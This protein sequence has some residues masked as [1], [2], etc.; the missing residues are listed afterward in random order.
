MEQAR[1]GLEGKRRFSAAAPV[2]AGADPYA[3]PFGPPL[4]PAP[5]DPT[6]VRGAF[7]RF[8]SRGVSFTW[9]SRPLALA[10]AALV[11]LAATT[12]S[13]QEV[14]DREPNQ[15]G[16]VREEALEPAYA[17]QN[18]HPA[19]G[20]EVSLFA[21]EQDFPIGNPV[22]M[23]FDARGRL[24]VAT[25]PSYPQRLP[26]EAPDDKIVILE[27]R[28]GDGHAD[29]HTVFAS[30]LHLPTG[31][32]LGDGGAYVA[33]QPNLMFLEDTDGDD[34]ADRHEVI[35]HGFGTEDSHHSISAFTWGPGGALYFQEGTFHHSQVETPHGPVRLV[36]A[37]V[38]RY[39]PRRFHL[40]V[41]VSYPF[42][43]PWGHV[44]D[45]W[46][47]NF[48]AD[49]SGGDNYF[50]AP[51]TINAP[52]PR[53]RR[54]MNVF[55]SIVRPT[56]GCEIV[57]SRHFPDE[58]QG[59][60]LINNTIGFQGIKQHRVIEEGS[61][62]TSEEVEPLLYSTDIN[63]RPVDLQFGPD[64]SLYV[65]DWF[66]PLIGHMQ[67]SLRDE[68]RDH[69]HGRIWRVRH[70]SRPLLDA[71]DIAGASTPGLVQ[72]LE[73]PEDRTRYRV[74]R[75]LRERPRNEVLAAAEA[76]LA[77]IDRREAEVGPSAELE[78]R[79][80]EALWLHQNL[81]VVAPDLLARLLESPEPR[82]RAAAT[83]VARFWRQR[84]DDPL[85]LLAARVE[86]SFPRAR[87][88]ALV[89]LSYLESTPAALAA[90]GAL[91]QP[92]DY[93]LDYTLGETVDVLEGSWLPELESGRGPPLL[94]ALPPDAAGY[95]LDR[96]ST[97][98]LERL[99]THDLVDRAV[100]RRADA[101]LERQR[102]ALASL[103][104]VE[105]G[106]APRG[107]TPAALLT[108][109]L[110][111]LDESATVDDEQVD[112]IAL[113]LM[114]QDPADLQA[115]RDQLR[116][117]ASGASQRNLRSAALAALIV[118]AGDP[119]AGDV[120][121]RRPDDEQW[122]D[123]L[124]G[125]DH[126]PAGLRDGAWDDV[127]ALLADSRRRTPAVREAAVRTLAGI[128]GDARRSFDR[129]AGLVFDPDLRLAA[130]E[131]LGELTA[132]AP[133]AWPETAGADTLAAL[134]E[135]V[136]G[137]IRSAPPALLT[138]PHYRDVHD[139]GLRIA[140][141]MI[142]ESGGDRGRDLREDLVNLG[143]AIVTLRPI[144]HQM[145]FDLE[146]F[147]VRAGGPVEISFENVDVMPHNV[148]ITRP[149]ALEEVGRAADAEAER[150][151]ASAAASGYVPRTP[152]VLFRTGLVQPG[153]TE[154]LSFRAPAEPGLYPF[155]CTFPGHWIL[156]QGTM[157]VVERLDGTAVTRF[158]APRL[159]PDAPLRPFVADWSYDMLETDVAPVDDARLDAA[160]GAE[161]SVEVALAR[162]RQLFLEAGCASCHEI[163]GA[164]AQIGPAL[165]DLAN[166]FGALDT[167]KHI[168]EPSI[169]VAEDYRTFLVET[170]DGGFHS[171]LLVASD[172][173]AVQIR[174]NP[175]DPDRIETIPRDR[176][177]SL[178]PSA[179]S[180]MPSGLLS[181]LQPDEVR[182]LIRYVLHS[183]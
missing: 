131:A 54:R 51:L 180:P 137:A 144:P 55:T 96:L 9:A 46:G 33:Q 39:K 164:G 100:L 30:G 151:P 17:L 32:E 2:A 122:L 28:D 127:S 152:L 155:V 40:E 150:N 148:V 163:G 115:L 138:S 35:L 97:R 107:L 178:E 112:R 68:R 162:G 37:G 166:R 76:W 130:L 118:A 165:D 45:R 75:E 53:K 71:P 56:S 129:L 156:M 93:Y 49:A 154:I 140:D 57:S 38:F 182:D 86:D 67:Y 160:R 72:L 4:L 177:E 70:G 7:R 169:E 143:P 116:A 146:E 15:G 47:Q 167:L 79:R 36:D 13:A 173:E 135:P 176:I 158:A 147:T 142:E 14:D 48:I 141:R 134:A 43:N 8:R 1:A 136:L 77:D 99:P 61:G 21:S 179:L 90:L 29:H 119:S 87:L 80:L 88:E 31:F 91:E 171:G 85:A 111:S 113:H 62:F 12:G 105:P 89:G 63:F 23:A 5:V 153:E 27:D 10:A 103:A 73:S 139:L 126:L 101:S 16:A 98:K 58:A 84:L 66:N 95:L 18:L 65:V 41:F 157:R 60:F 50:G 114:E 42:A 94:G 110:R 159:A 149:G 117:L 82:A 145:L 20:Y 64:G 132:N 120:L 74:R 174:S 59:N 106:G 19:E 128:T 69:D 183:P 104:D 44:F 175:L 22:A 26:D 168:L 181:T 52:Y 34:V 24:W 161:P 78:H 92:T 170:R 108:G 133:G 102:E 11:A 81:N 6:A 3:L 123:W 124:Q 125:L 172:D 121:P 83:R 25:M 109:E